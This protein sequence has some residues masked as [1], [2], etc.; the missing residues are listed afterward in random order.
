MSNVVVKLFTRPVVTPA[1]CKKCGKPSTKVI[2]DY[3]DECA[4]ALLPESGVKTDVFTLV[5]VRACRFS[6]GWRERCSGTRMNFCSSRS[7]TR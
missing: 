2:P 6:R 3:C 1:L 4:L 5:A 7:L